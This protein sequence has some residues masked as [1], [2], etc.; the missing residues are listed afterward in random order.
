MNHWILGCFTL[1]L[2]ANL[3]GADPELL[4][5]QKADYKL[6]KDPKR[7]TSLLKNGTFEAVIKSYHPN[8]EG[9]PAME[10]ALDYKFDVQ[11]VGEQSGV[12]TGL[13]DYEYFTEEFLVNLRKNGKYE[14]E[15][16]KAVHQGY[17]DAKTLEGKNY[18]HCDLIFLYDIKDT[19]IRNSLLGFLGSIVQADN[20]SDIEDLKVLAHVYPGVPVISAVKLDISGK[21][22][23]MAIKA[24]ADYQTP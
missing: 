12:E 15:N 11:M 5:G 16:F 19:V 1:V 4:V 23:G 2:S 3:V 21:Y 13:L 17:K 20:H 7:T 9:G 8:A 6:D 22:S 10:V 24:G 14:S 18:P